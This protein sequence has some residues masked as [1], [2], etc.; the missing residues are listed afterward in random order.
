[1]RFSLNLSLLLVVLAFMY[2][3]ATM[4]IMKIRRFDVPRTRGIGLLVLG[5]GIGQF[6]I[7]A[8]GVVPYLSGQGVS[9]SRRL[10]YFERESDPIG[11]LIGLVVHIGLGVFLIVGCTYFGLR[12]IRHGSI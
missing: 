1:M 10:Q 9:L 4:L 3:A 11:A 6:G 8:L 2:G 7:V 12:L 5:W